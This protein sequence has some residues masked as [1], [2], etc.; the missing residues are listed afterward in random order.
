MRAAPSNSRKCPKMSQNVPPEKDSLWLRFEGTGRVQRMANAPPGHPC[1]AARSIAKVFWNAK[2][3]T[4]GFWIGAVA[5][6]MS[7]ADDR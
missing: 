5:L 3:R 7:V 4:L 6:S 2:K 1:E